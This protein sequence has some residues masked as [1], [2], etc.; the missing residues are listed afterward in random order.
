MNEVYSNSLED[1]RLL[2][3]LRHYQNNR[4]EV[5]RTPPKTGVLGGYRVLDFHQFLSKCYEKKS[6]NLEQKLS[7]E[8]NFMVIEY[9]TASESTIENMFSCCL[10]ISHEALDDACKVLSKGSY[11]H[12]KNPENL[13]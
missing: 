8:K 4:R 12:A 7:S 1:D 6:H 13:F 2:G 3:R 10:H 11:P 9:S 5:R